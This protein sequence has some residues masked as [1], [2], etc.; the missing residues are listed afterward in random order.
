MSAVMEVVD[1]SAPFFAPVSSDLIDGLLG[2][3]QSM[4]K[5]IEN[6]ASMIDGEMSSAME[7][8]F[9]GNRD[10]DRGRGDFSVERVFRKEGA[11]F[12]LN[13]AYWSKTLAMTDVLDCMPQKRR[14]FWHAQLS[15]KKFVGSGYDSETVPSL[16]DFEEGTVRATLSDMLAMRA[17]FLSERVDGIFRALSSDHVT[18]CPQGFSKRMILNSVYTSYASHSQCGHINDLR[19]VIAKFMGHDEPKYN[20][21]SRIAEI[22]RKRHGEWITIDGGAMRMRVYLKGTAHLEIHPDMAFR[23][24]QVLANLHPHAIPA[25][26]RTK[27]KKAHKEFQMMSRPLP[28]AVVDILAQMKRATRAIKQDGNWRQPYRYENVDNALKYDHYGQ[29]DKHVLA[30]VRNV[31]KSIG[32]IESTEG[33]WQFDYNPNEIID[34]I[35]T[36]GCIPDQKAHQFYPT[37]ESV[38]IAAIEMA[39]IGDEDKC[40]EPSA[41]QGGLADY[42]PK[43]R[44]RCVEISKLHCDILAAKGFDVVQADFIE[45]ATKT[46]DRFDVAVLNP[47][48]SDGRALLHTQ[49]AATLVKSGGRLVAILPAS[50]KGKDILPGWSAEWSHVFENEFAGTSVSVVIFSGEKP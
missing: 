6:I 15:G 11:I 28:F 25:E 7:Y 32:G 4:R 22:A 35:V 31:L 43:D 49:T 38:A 44:T 34:D 19:C 10:P 42:M 39:Q 12:A 47:P 23:L 48:F 37:P 1:D 21:T 27:Q 16:P 8:F 45:W 5:R 3:Y 50:F 40:L 33:W 30:E 2:Q 9:E 29:P 36:S 46:A 26:F 24:N 14:D 20:S 13:S 41:G 17:M 18:N